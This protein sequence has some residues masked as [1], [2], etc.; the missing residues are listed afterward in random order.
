MWERSDW[1]TLWSNGSI[2]FAR[3]SYH[4]ERYRWTPPTLGGIDAVVLVR[5]GAFRR[6]ADGV[7]H[8]VDP[9]T[10]Y[11]RRR[12]EEVSVANFTGEPEEFNVIQLAPSLLQDLFAEPELPGGPVPITPEID[13]M[14][15]VLT[16]S[17]S[18][19]DDDV[20]VEEQ[21]LELVTSV[22]A[23][24]RAGVVR[25]SRRSTE[26]NW[27][28]LVSDACEVLHTSSGD[29]SVQELARTVGC[30]PFHLSR[31]FRAVTGSPI[32]QYR[33]RLRV[34]AVLDRLSEG[35]EDL[36]SLAN[37]VGFFDHSHMTRCVVAQ[38]GEPPSVLRRRLRRGA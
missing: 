16:A 9:H 10:G 30:S 19:Q 17:V 31:V 4:A 11:F 37:A 27:R 33:L 28:S 7:D 1:T 2:T 15:R 24:R 26:P 13:L 35:E 20:A 23:Q 29:M 8:V 18:R 5:C 21:V 12:G 3:V 6:R 32:S 36:S 14:H 22:V 25:G 34:R 38:V